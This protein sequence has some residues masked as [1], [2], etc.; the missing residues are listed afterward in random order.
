MSREV[1]HVGAYWESRRE[2]VEECA[3]RADLFFH[4]LAQCESSLGQWY[5]AGRVA[6]GSPGHLV[7][8]NDR[9]ELKES[10]LR[11]RN[12]TDLDKSVI[13]D[14][15][16]SMHVWNQRPDARA[17]ILTIRCG[18]YTDRGSNLCLLK[19]PREGEAAE[20][21]LSAPML[22][23][24][25]ECMVTAWDPDWGVVTS[26][27]VQDLIPSA[28]EE[29]AEVGWMNY[30]SRRRGTVPPLPAPVRIEP[31]GTLGML[32]ILTP[33]RFTASNPEHIALGL[34]VRELLGRAGVLK[35]QSA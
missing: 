18:A 6:R 33:E 11:G 15:G 13:E 17:T 3:R 9:E 2:D 5:R 25:L 8:T 28:D 1:Y 7:R 26:N 16:F 24:I 27:K 30:F 31:V 32:V 29:N 10:L 19:P 4:L 35:P 34:R 12:R 22:A 14:L 23:R 21:M 20:R